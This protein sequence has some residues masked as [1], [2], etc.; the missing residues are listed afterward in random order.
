M[1]FIPVVPEGFN[2]AKCWFY[3]LPCTTSCCLLLKI[4]PLFRSAVTYVGT[5]LLNVA[6]CISVMIV[7]RQDLPLSVLFC[8]V[9]VSAN[10]WRSLSWLFS[11]VIWQTQQLSDPIKTQHPITSLL[12]YEGVSLG[13]RHS[14]MI[15]RRSHPCWPSGTLDNDEAVLT[16]TVTSHVQPI[17]TWKYKH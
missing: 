15:Q 16:S 6:A 1:S 13:G 7:S 3:D 12:W 9:R 14:L 11:Q 4:A 5:R 17:K 2:V 10:K 8:L